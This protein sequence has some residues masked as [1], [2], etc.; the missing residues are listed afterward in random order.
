MRLLMVGADLPAL[1]AAAPDVDVT[2]LL[3]ATTHD[4]GMPL[5]AGVRTIFVDD[6]KS[7]DAALNGLLRAGL[8]AG[9]FDAVYAYDDPALMTAA[10]LARM[11]G[12]RGHAP[13]T[14]ALFRD[15]YLQKR[16]IREAGLPVTACSLIEDI[17]ELPAGYRLPYDRAVVKPVA[18]M[19]TQSTFVVRGD[20]ELARVSAQC[21]ANGATARNFVV[22]EF[23]EGEEWFADGYLS[24]GELRFL[25][26]GRYA[27][28][29]LSA[30]LERAPVQTYSLDPVADKAAYDLAS[31]L[32]GAALR[33]L[34][35]TDG[36][37]HMELFQLADGTL[38]FSECAAR[39]A[40]G[41]IRDQ[42][43]WKFGV[44]LAADG[45]RAL[46]EPVG[47][48]VTR[49]R[50]GVVASTFLPLRPGVVLDYPSATEVLA[51]PDVV[52][53]RIFVPKGMR[54]QGGA[55]NTFARMGEVTVHTPDPDTARRRLTEL[56]DWFT[57]HIEVL[58]LAPTLRELYTDPRNAGFVHA[59]AADG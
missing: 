5:P 38:M 42:I 30:V 54:I 39:R 41:P 24:E 9:S 47:E 52:H 50:D 56:A 32:V 29:C 22:E 18:G 25:S 20:A 28:P 23:V 51:Q 10:V 13:Q 2:V 14:V 27:Q 12:A 31:P 16:R 57:A 37:F 33:A 26:L 17:R 49:A 21:R 1:A 7:I 19:A 55:A 11:L 53:A 46:L 43:R 4:G 58:P 35:L 40:G 36:V 59:A 3:G 48:P 34:G 8:G 15:K 44:D 45:V 6:H